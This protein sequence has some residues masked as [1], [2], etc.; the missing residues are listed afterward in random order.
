MATK[1][2]YRDPA[3]NYYVADVERAVRFYVENFGFQETFRTPKR[4][5][6]HHVEV[7]LG[8]LELGLA[9]RD[10]ARRM[11]GIEV[12]QGGSPRAE[13][14][15]WTD[16]VD[17]AYAELVASGV[18]GLSAPHTFIGVLRAA[19]VEDPDGNPVEIVSRIG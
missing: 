19:W 6:P 17:A 10:A 13:V 9:S 2:L 4:G 12:G 15:I 5:D 11:H 3:V 16:D 1:F 14:V 18:P 8:G 7:R